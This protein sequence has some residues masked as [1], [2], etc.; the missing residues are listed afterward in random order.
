M[1]SV[2]ISDFN[3]RTGVAKVRIS[4]HK[5]ITVRPEDWQGNHWRTIEERDTLIKNVA[6]KRHN[7]KNGVVIP[8]QVAG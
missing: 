8:T 3:T 2:R 6:I 4:G 1:I 5:V 7:I